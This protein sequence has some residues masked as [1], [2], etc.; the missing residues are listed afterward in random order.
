[1]KIRLRSLVFLLFVAAVCFAQT[2]TTKPTSKPAAAK[3]VAPAAWFP[4]WKTSIG[5]TEEEFKNA[6]LDQLTAPQGNLL[7]A[8]VYGHR[9]YLDCGP[10]YV[11]AQKDENN[12]VHIF[13]TGNAS[14]VEF[15]GRLRLKLSA[16][17]DVKMVSSADDA[18]L[19]ISILTV[20]NEVGSTRVGLTVAT[21]VSEICTMK[22]PSDGAG[23]KFNHSIDALI[24]TGP[25]EEGIASRIASR[26]A[27]SVEASDFDTV[28]Q[29][30]A[31][32]L[33][34]LPH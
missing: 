9:P 17:K 12:F 29:N 27:N 23:S 2:P 28:R 19:I 34:L 3:P 14:D 6:G 20:S 13:A 10:T 7:W 33:K 11:A 15:V 32:M 1:M 22:T 4:Y 24:N 31:Q 18:D 16:I 26:I 5:V 30:H 8:A 21:S 25:D